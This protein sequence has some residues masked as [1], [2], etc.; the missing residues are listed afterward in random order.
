MSSKMPEITRMTQGKPPCGAAMRLDFFPL[1]GLNFAICAM[2]SPR[3]RRTRDGGRRLVVVKWQ[4]VEPSALQ[5]FVREL[6]KGVGPASSRTVP[7][8]GSGCAPGGLSNGG[9]AIGREFA[10]FQPGVEVHRIS[11][12]DPSW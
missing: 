8:A 12:F 3:F 5:E 6:E 4:T 7:R 1:A 10:G 9:M 11:H 2:V